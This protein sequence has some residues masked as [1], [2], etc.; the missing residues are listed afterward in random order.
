MLVCKCQQLHS[1]CLFTIRKVMNKNAYLLAA[2]F[3][4]LVTCVLPFGGQGLRLIADIHTMVC[5]LLA[6]G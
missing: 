5:V 3:N 6:R 1:F 2:A 4:D